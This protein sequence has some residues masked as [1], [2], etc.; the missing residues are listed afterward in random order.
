MQSNSPHAGSPDDA[1]SHKVLIVE[2][3]LIIALDLE[4][5]VS[6]MGFAVA[7]LASSREHAVMLAPFADIAL[8]DV[9][10]SDGA[11]GPEIGRLLAEKFGVTVVF[12]T[13]NIEMVAAG[14]N[15]T[16]G[17][18]SKPVTPHIVEETLR[19]AIARR[20]NQCAM[21]PATM[22]IFAN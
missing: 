9:N 1:N 5:A 15:G 22:K 21:A 17:V 20:N 13:G 19:Y 14:V 11:S 16:L 4:D 10:L 12:M 7:G 3:D 18:V 8:V 6:R 2:D